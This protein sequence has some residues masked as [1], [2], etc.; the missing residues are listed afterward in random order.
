MSKD[1]IVGIIVGTALIIIEM[2]LS[3][4]LKPLIPEPKTVRKSLKKLVFFLFKFGLSIIFLITIIILNIS[5]D[6]S[7]NDN[8][9]FYKILTYLYVTYV[10]AKIAYVIVDIRLS[11]KEKSIRVKSKKGK[12]K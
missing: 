7:D 4:Y 12:R 3:K 5:Q 6:Y 8:K 1:I 2:I 10:L 11:R 9:I